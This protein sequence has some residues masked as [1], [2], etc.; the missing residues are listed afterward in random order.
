MECALVLDTESL[1]IPHFGLVATDFDYDAALRG[2]DR[3]WQQLPPAELA[4]SITVTNP[5]VASKTKLT[6]DKPVKFKG[7]VVPAGTN[8][9]EFKKFDGSFFNVHVPELTPLAIHSA[10]IKSGFEIP[11]DTYV[12]K[13]EW[14][15]AKG[16]TFSDAVKVFIDV[17]L[18]A[19]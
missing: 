9:L 2:D 17:D 15:T 13:L 19:K 1:R 12:V 6:L 5:T 16:E 7:K 3:L 4:L 10:T 14:S 11:A 8:L 18:P